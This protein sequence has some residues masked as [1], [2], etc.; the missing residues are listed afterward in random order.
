MIPLEELYTLYLQHPVVC[1]DTRQL[2]EGCLFF[3]LRGITFD[4][5]K[6]ALQ[7]LES[8]AAYAVVDDPEVAVQDDR[9]L[10]V[11][12]VLQTLQQLA[13][14]HRKALGLPVIAITGTNGKT[15]T[16]EL[17]AAV[18]S[19]GY[20]LLYTEGNL[21]NH[22]GVPLTLLR[23]RAEHQLALIE[24]GASKLGDI[25]ELC[26][27]AEPDY[28]LITNIGEA[29]LEGFG[30][31]EGVRKTKGEL[32]E[33]VRSRGG[34]LFVHADDPTLLEMSRGAERVIT[35]AEHVP[36]LV[37]GEVAPHDGELFLHFRWI[38]PALPFPLQEVRTHLVG[39]YNL[40]NALA[41]IAIGLFFDLPV[42]LINEALSSYVPSNSRSQLILSP[43]GNRIIADAYN[44]NPS[45]MRT[46]IH[47]FLHIPPT[48]APRILI[49]GD[50]N[51]LGQESDQAHQRLW[52]E[53]LQ[54]GTR[55]PLRVL[56]CGP[57]WVALRRGEGET[58]AS[59]QELKA[60]LE[61]HPLSESLI[62]VK[63]SNGIHLSELLP[64]L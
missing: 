54:Y 43:Q 16:K 55:Q 1:T 38:A 31:L 46:A 51:E 25:A 36:A 37:E 10:L 11:A 23:L 53:L 8:G 32:Y 58:F 17:T 34:V 40:P 45:S 5:N 15:T 41:A 24:M 52:T 63:G 44:A 22:I 19:R 30:S 39:D 33:S 26:A 7:A 20:R 47:N 28:G 3:A 4:G 27:I 50:M 62:L 12:D 64:L 29:H 18:L 59:V 6:F 2:S 35:C 42:V 48:D 21:N 57:R 61:A 49:L 14:H 9:L 56:L 60:H 13:H